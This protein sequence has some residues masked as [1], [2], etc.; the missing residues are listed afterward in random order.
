M[1][2][3]FCRAKI[4]VIAMTLVTSASQQ[5][6]SFA[7][8]KAQTQKENASTATARVTGIGGVFI[9]SK[10][11]KALTDWYKKNLGMTLEPWGGAILKW[12]DDKAEDHGVT[13]WHAMPNDAPEIAPSKSGFMINYRIDS[14]EKMVKQLKNNGVKPLK[15]PESHENGKFL[16]LMDPD[17]NK[18]E[19]WE[20][21]NW[22]EKNK[23]K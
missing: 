1:L 19:L 22:D 9:K 8:D 18:V 17:G 21:M 14:M 3:R 23:K 6:A 16:W 11:T 5:I 12:T 20:P 4:T 10:N 7:A 15:G 2:D 13:V